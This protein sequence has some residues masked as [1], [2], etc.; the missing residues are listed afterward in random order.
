MLVT[1][2]TG[3][4]I[5]TVIMSINSA[6]ENGGILWIGKTGTSAFGIG[7]SKCH[8]I[9]QLRANSPFRRLNRVILIKF[10]QLYDVMNYNHR[11]ILNGDTEN[12]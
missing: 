2:D 9:L 8:S 7:G 10:H 3:K 12:Y 4:R 1:G 11:Q 5:R 6:Q